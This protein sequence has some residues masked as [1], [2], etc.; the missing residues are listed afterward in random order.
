L[1]G[2]PSILGARNRGEGEAGLFF[3]HG[4][5]SRADENGFE[6]REQ[7]SAR[8]KR[9]RHVA[10]HRLKRPAGG[11]VETNAA[12]GVAYASSDFEQLGAQGFDLGGA[13]RAWQLQT[14]EVNQVVRGGVQEQAESVGQKAVTAQ[15]VGA[16]AV[17]ELLDAVSR[18]PPR[19]L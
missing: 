9:Q 12:G 3:E 5:A 17:L 18:T 16:K 10:E 11:E 13:P 15:T 2:W 7:P 4:S 1:R 14:K 6:K 19:S 8:V